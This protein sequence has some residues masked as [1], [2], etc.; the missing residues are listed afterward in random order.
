MDAPKPQPDGTPQDDLDAERLAE[1]TKMSLDALRTF[2][3]F[4]TGRRALRRDPA[5]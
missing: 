3:D 1:L 5:E 2:L 4:H